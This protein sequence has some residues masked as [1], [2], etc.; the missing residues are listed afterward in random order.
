[1]CSSYRPYRKYAVEL[2]ITISLYTIAVFISIFLLNRYPNGLVRIP[3]AL[4]P[5]LPASFVPI[6]VVRLLKHVDEFHLKMH[7]ETLGF[8]F[9]GTAVFSFGYGWLQLAGLPQVSWH[10]VWVLMGIMWIIGAA[11]S[12]WRYR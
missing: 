2:A 4:L 10:Y 1:M 8:A 12:A 11:W 3:I 5:M 7:L 9:A 6:V